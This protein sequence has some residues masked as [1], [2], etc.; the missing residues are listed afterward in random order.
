MSEQKKDYDGAL[1]AP[2]HK[3]EE[4]KKQRPSYVDYVMGKIK[5]PPAFKRDGKLS[6]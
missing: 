1:Y 4:F 3:V 5:Y 2:W 6:E